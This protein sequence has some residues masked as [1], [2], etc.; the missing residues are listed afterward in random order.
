MKA[1]VRGLLHFG[2]TGFHVF[3]PTLIIKALK[4]RSCFR[5]EAIEQ[6]SFVFA[7]WRY[8]ALILTET[9]TL[10]AKVFE[11]YTD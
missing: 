7:F 10:P 11:W 9:C 6:R 5:V 3:Q 2:I 8:L 1:E 4:A